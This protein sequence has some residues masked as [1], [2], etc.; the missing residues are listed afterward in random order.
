MK[1]RY[2]FAVLFC[3]YILT[4]CFLCFTKGEQLPDMPSTWFGLP[5]DKVA[6]FIMFLPF[7]PL[8]YATF[9]PADGGLWRGLAVAM[10]CTAVGVGLAFATERIQGMLGYRTEDTYDMFSDIIGLTAG[11]LLSI[12]T[13]AIQHLKR[14]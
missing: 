12:A 1:R 14:R 7:T 5:A 2:I 11:A 13:V 10:I 6:H 8:A 4:V 9:A 3:L